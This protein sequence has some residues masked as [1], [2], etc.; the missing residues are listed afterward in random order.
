MTAA[1]AEPPDDAELV[2]IGAGDLPELVALEFEGFLGHE[3]WS[4]ASWRAEVCRDNQCAFGLRV[5]GRLVAAAL[6]SAWAPDAELLRIIVA[7]AHRRRHFAARLLDA[8]TAWATSR[9]ATRMLLEVRDDNLGAL[10][11]Y[12]RGGFVRMSERRNYYGP[13]ATAL[14]LVHTLEPGVTG[15]PGDATRKDTP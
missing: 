7:H 10:A 5:D 11:L 14:V 6:V 4:E 2:E 1:P 13:H 9:G 3:R 8:A 12:Q 15:A